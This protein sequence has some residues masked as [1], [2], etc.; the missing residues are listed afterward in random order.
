MKGNFTLHYVEETFFRVLGP[1]LKIFRKI[2]L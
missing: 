1:Y 2:Q